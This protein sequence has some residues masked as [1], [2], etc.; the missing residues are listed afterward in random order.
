MYY[1]ALGQRVLKAGATQRIY[2]V[3]DEEG[4]TIGEYGQ[5]Y[6]GTV[7]TVYLGNLPIAVLTPSL[8]FYVFA[9]HIGTPLVLATPEGQ[10]A[11]DWRYHDPFGNNAP[12]N[13]T[14]LTAY[15]HRFPGQIADSE[16]GLFY[17]YF[18]DYDPQLGRYI[19]SDPI[20]LDGGINT[21]A[22]VRGNPI[23]RLDSFGLFD[24][25]HHKSIT[26]DVLKA[27]G[28]GRGSREE[29]AQMVADVDILPG[30][31]KPDAEHSPWHAMCA[32]GQSREDSDAIREALTR[33]ALDTCQKT[34]LAMAM[35]A[36]QDSA[37]GGHKN[38]QV[39]N[40]HVSFA[41]LKADM[42]PS[43]DSVEEARSKTAAILS[44]FEEKCGCQ[45]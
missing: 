28:W 29:M 40:G 22:Y 7:E 41:H 3:Y 34:D 43:A 16:T 1:N 20:G 37:A 32:P 36:A 25:V 6:V 2:Y 26:I 23:S 14:L 21:Y 30:S 27:D 17:N 42:F 18:R 13:S 4:R 19:E 31:Q 12:N 11:W 10:I 5:Q 44:A 35:H 9:D 15:D 38:C 8:N 39:W 33:R 24:E 45:K